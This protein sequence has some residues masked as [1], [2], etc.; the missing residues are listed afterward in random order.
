M[1]KVAILSSLMATQSIKIKENPRMPSSDAYNDKLELIGTDD[2]N[3][4]SKK[5]EDSNDD[6]EEPAESK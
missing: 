2:E 5:R 3:V 1:K 4:F 6:D